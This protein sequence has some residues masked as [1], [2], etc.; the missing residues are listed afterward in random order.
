MPYARSIYITIII[1]AVKRNF[2]RTTRIYC[3]IAAAVAVLFYREIFRRILFRFFF[4]Q[5]SW[6]YS[7][8]DII[9]QQSRE[10]NIVP[11]NVCTTTLLLLLIFHC[12]SVHTSY[13]AADRRYHL[14]VRAPKLHRAGLYTNGII[15]YT[16]SARCKEQKIITF[17]HNLYTRVV[18]DWIQD[19]VPPRI[20]PCMAISPVIAKIFK[21]WF[22]ISTHTSGTRISQLFRILIEFN[23]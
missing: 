5:Q 7:F 15:K 14:Y 22:F 21:S 8:S 12:E 3:H 18:F 13:T 9:V 6:L 11:W 16:S 1:C 17:Y 19:H 2:L 10:H 20:Y 23:V 4:S